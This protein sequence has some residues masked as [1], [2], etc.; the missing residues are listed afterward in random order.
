MERE[1]SRMKRDVAHRSSA[2]TLRALSRDN[3]YFHMGPPRDDV[4]GVL[5]LPNIGLRASRYLARR[6]GANRE[7][8]EEVCAKEAAKLLGAGPARGWTEGE[9]QAWR[10]WAPLVQ[11]IPGLENWSAADRLALAGVMRA[12]G[13]RRESEFVA[14]FD[15]HAPLRR[16]MRALARPID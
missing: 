9:R 12:K 3:V 14:R 4:I 10:R 5:E 13:G 15:A 7:E 16:G 8:A 2:T 1:L 6:F 11:V